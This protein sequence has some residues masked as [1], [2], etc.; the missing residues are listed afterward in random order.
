MVFNCNSKLLWRC[1]VHFLSQSVSTGLYEC[2]PLHLRGYS[3]PRTMRLSRT[4]FASLSFSSVFTWRPSDAESVSTTGIYASLLAAHLLTPVRRRRRQTGPGYWPTC[5]SPLEL[6]G[7]SCYP[8]EEPGHNMCWFWR[9][10]HFNTTGH[11]QGL[12][13]E[14]NLCDRLKTDQWSLDLS[15]I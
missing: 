5:K 7:R 4:M 11:I 13:G 3:R 12:R 14:V 6:Q 8:R 15:F 9:F 10:S 1:E 2:A